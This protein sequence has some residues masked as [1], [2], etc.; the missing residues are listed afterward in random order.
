M[1]AARLYNILAAAL[2]TGPQLIFQ[3]AVLHAVGS[4]CSTNCKVPKVLLISIIGSLMSGAYNGGAAVASMPQETCKLSARLA[5]GIAAG[6]HILCALIIRS[7]AFSFFVT[8][9]PTLYIVLYASSAFAVPCV[10]FCVFTKPVCNKSR[11]HRQGK[12]LLHA[13]A[14][15]HVSLSLGP[16]YPLT[17][18]AYGRE[19]Q[20]HSSFHGLLTL[21][22]MAHLMLDLGGIILIYKAAFYKASN[23]LDN[24]PPPCTAIADDVFLPCTLFLVLLSL[25]VSLYIL[26]II[27]YLIIDKTIHTS[28][29]WTF[30]SSLTIMPLMGMVFYQRWRLYL[31]R[32]TTP[33]H[34]APQVNV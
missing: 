32:T 7:L 29:S 20:G 27:A 17:R 9:A 10:L 22:T 30:Q 15:G 26:S 11:L 16:L 6:I 25:A 19:L 33:E 1:E 12:K 21:A 14:N 24:Y 23:G 28:Q 18:D 3:Y 8:G 34:P 5:M 4:N 2:E 31:P 13:I